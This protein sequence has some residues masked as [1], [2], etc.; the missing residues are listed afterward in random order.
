MTLTIDIKLLIILALYHLL[1]PKLESSMEA[2]KRMREEGEMS[3]T[4]MGIQEKENCIFL[5]NFLFPLSF[6]LFL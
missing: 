4:A 2:I 3:D 5:I 6:F 1:I